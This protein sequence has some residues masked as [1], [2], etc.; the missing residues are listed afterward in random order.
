MVASVVG[1]QVKI[2]VYIATVNVYVSIHTV[3]LV[4]FPRVIEGSVKFTIPMFGM[5]KPFLPY[6]IVI[7][8]GK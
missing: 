8:I 5:V 6:S 3:A 1:M 2:Y 4:T 7:V